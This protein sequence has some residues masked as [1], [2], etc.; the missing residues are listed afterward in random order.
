[1]WGF[2]RLFFFILFGGS[3]NSSFSFPAVQWKTG[4]KCTQVLEI[5]VDPI[6]MDFLSLYE[7]FLNVYDV[8]VMI[9]FGGI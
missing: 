4:M 7:Y 8:Q 2:C 3:E 5:I 1:M 6:Q 9:D